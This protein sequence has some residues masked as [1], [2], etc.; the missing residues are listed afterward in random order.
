MPTLQERIEGGLFGL[1][2]GD[3]LGVPY[4]FQSSKNIPPQPFIE[5][6][7]PK[8]FMRAHVGTPP[9]TW[10]DDG[11]QALVLLASLLACGKLDTQDFG[12]RLV[13][14]YDA[15][16]MAVDNRVFDVGIQT[17]A[18]IR[19][20]MRGEP[21]LD[22]GGTDEMSNGNG[23][24]MRVLPLV[25]WHQGSDLDLATDAMLQSR[26]THGHLRSQVC[27]A[28]YCL[29]ARRIIEESLDPW[30]EA[31]EA[32]RTI[33]GI[34][35]REFS[36]LDY[37]VRP[38][39]LS[40]GEGSGYVVDSLRSAYWAMQA[41]GYEKVVR[42]AIALGNDT[43]TTA[44]IAGGTAGLRDG[45]SAIPQRWRDDLRGQEIVAPLLSELI[46]KRCS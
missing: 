28:L 14:W 35:S 38:Y 5:F 16:Y 17:G 6:S 43:D 22:A 46:K 45:I 3:A 20:L 41:G 13:Q 24:L 31:V 40:L 15:G 10:S 4:E 32:L 8:T 44:C 34:D 11:A 30:R 18:A 26:V 29:W 12:Q 39:E 19:Q 9:G 2:I 36:E 21:A 33:W 1:L 23:S 7:P 27:C 42:A 25:L 37:Y